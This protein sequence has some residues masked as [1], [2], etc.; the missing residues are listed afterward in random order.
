MLAAGEVAPDP[1]VLFVERS[2]LDLGFGH[3]RL[4]R[5]QS[6]RGDDGVAQMSFGLL[7]LVEREVKF[8]AGGAARTEQIVCFRVETRA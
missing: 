6:V 2:A 8:L 4:G 1:V 5:L 3:R 7:M